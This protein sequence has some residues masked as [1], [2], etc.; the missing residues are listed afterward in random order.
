MICTAAT[1]VIT[2]YSIHYTKLYD[3]ITGSEPHPEM[4]GK[5]L[6][7]IAALWGVDQREACRRLIPGGA[8]YFQMNE[9]DV[10]RVLAH[11]RTMIGSDG[12]P[13]DVRPHPRLW[14]TFPRV[15]G[16][17]NNFV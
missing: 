15:L 16:H 6:A 11:P 13:H 12:L 10:R 7:D 9:E 4:A 14:G 5:L 3:I 8:C 2:S 17:R 1:I